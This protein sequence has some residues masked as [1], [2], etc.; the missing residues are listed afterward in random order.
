MVAS[1]NKG[2]FKIGRSKYRP[3]EVETDRIWEESFLW[4]EKVALVLKI[5]EWDIAKAWAALLRMHAVPKL[6]AAAMVVPPLLGL[7]STQKHHNITSY[8]VT[9]LLIIINL[10]LLA[11]THQL[12][13]L[14]YNFNN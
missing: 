12:W 4:K 14:T 2:K 10:L 8:V 13:V 7:P 9:L 6:V 11:E 1:I 5:W 3:E